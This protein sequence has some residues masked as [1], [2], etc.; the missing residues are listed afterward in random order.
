MKKILMVFLVLLSMMVIPSFKVKALEDGFYAAEYVDGVYIKKF[1]GSSGKYEQMRFFR[2]K[3]D[4]QAVY[5]LETWENL[6]E[7]KNI[8]GYDN[9]AYNYVNFDYNIW[10]K[11]ML[12]AYYGYG[13][14]NHTDSKWFAITQYMIWKLTSPDSD[15]Y[16]TDKLNG[17]K[18]TKFEAEIN[19]INTLIDNHANLSTLSNQTYEL[20]YKKDFTIVDTNHV[21]ENYDIT[22]NVG[23]KVNKVGNTLTV[24]K[25][26]PGESDIYLTKTGKRFSSMPVVYIDPNGQDILAPGNFYPI[27]MLI[28][29]HLPSSNI[30][31]QKQD[32]DNQNSIP[33]GDAKLKG[34][35]FQLLD[36][37]NQVVQEQTVGEEGKAVFEN[38]GYGD[39]YV[40]EIKS[41][42]GYLLNHE[43]IF[44]KVD[45]EQ[46]NVNFYNQVMT[47]TIVFH[48]YLKNP[49]TNQVVLEKNATFTIYNSKKEKVTTFTTD[50][51]G[52]YQI[53]LPYG[54]Y[55]ICQE[56]GMKNHSYVEDFE[57]DVTLDKQTQTFELYNEE[58]TANV[59]IINTDY[60]SNLP[61]LESGA[62]FRIKNLDNQEYIKNQD[63]NILLLETND[64]GNT[65]FLLLSSGNYQVEQV[66]SVS[67]YFVNPEVFTFQIDENTEFQWDENQKPY[68][69]IIVPNEKLKSKI[70][71]EKVI[72]GVKKCGF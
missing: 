28:S 63:G 72:E 46:E 71:I 55:T 30:I 57:V 4:N 17:N 16:F 39:Y 66:N 60:D 45:Q 7:S 32:F 11:V 52:T 3:S 25:D 53:T 56:S 70:E 2:R 31:V 29:F 21:I 36:Y 22:S 24:S 58:L 51:N 20:Q 47:N 64:L 61:I 18:I 1:R 15:I 10:E 5:C 68:L 62:T 41:G 23:L 40:K 50:D 33:Q 69:E 27:Y 42:E 48:K 12:T 14:E 26:E 38:V 9:E 54:K 34:S 49:I 35:T 44:L 59:K 13:Y 6:N 8:I 67:G 37:E 43:S 19:E 65:L